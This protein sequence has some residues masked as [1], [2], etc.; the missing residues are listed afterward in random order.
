M[1]AAR[2]EEA[3]E[4]G[5]G[6]EVYEWRHLTFDYNKFYLTRVTKMRALFM[7]DF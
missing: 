6:C 4:T 5:A 7:Y 3:R 2:F 1:D